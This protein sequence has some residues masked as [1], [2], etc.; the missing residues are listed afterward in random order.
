MR[1]HIRR[2][3]APPSQMCVL[4]LRISFAL[5]SARHCVAWAYECGQTRAQLPVSSNPVED[6]MFRDDLDIKPAACEEYEELLKT[7][8]V[9]LNE[10]NNGRAAIR[11]SGRKGRS[12][13]NELR[14]LQANFAKAYA[15][16]QTHS[17]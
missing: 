1:I 7:S 10:W 14:M 17:R 4:L 11:R 5:K 12:A 3:F 15:A 9:A 13:D 6:R 2:T 16:L 8:H